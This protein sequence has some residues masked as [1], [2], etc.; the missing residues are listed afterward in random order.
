MFGH[1]SLADALEVHSSAVDSFM[2]RAERVPVDRWREPVAEGKWSP[3]VIAAHLVSTYDVV[4][5]ELR[6]GAGMRVRTRFWQRWLLRLTIV[7]SILSGRGFPKGAIAPRET[8]PAEE[9]NQEESLS[10]FRNRAEDFEDAARTAPA[11]RC[12]THAYFGRA[13]VADGVLLCARHIQHHTD[14][15]PA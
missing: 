15:L 11:G 2:A 3:S 10:S 6:G 8:R 12:L 14:Q 1:T 7:P 13:S 4:T 9:L 5:R